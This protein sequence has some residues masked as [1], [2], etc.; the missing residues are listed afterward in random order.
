VLVVSDCG[1]KLLLIS[2]LGSDGFGVGLLRSSLC[3]FC[4]VCDWSRWP[5]IVAI[6]CGG[7]LASVSFVSPG[8]PMR[9]VFQSS[10]ASVVGVG[11]STAAWLKATRSAG[12]VDWL[13]DKPAK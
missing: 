10:S 11:L 4:L 12:F 13:T 5:L 2:S 6:D 1:K 9:K 3:L 8:K 7:Y